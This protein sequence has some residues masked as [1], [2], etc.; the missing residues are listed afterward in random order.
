MKKRNLSL[1]ISTDHF[2]E[3]PNQAKV[4]RFFN[5]KISDIVIYD[6]VG[7]PTLPNIIRK[8]DKVKCLIM[9]KSCWIKDSKI[10]IDLKLVQIMRTSPFS[11]I[12]KKT[13][14]VEKTPIRYNKNNQIHTPPPPPLPKIQLTLNVNSNP[15]SLISIKDIQE[16]RSKLK[17][18]KKK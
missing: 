7:N 15:L 8:E 17:N 14:M 6:E 9:L 12:N 5:V 10:G 4:L 3:Y 2:K 11:E 13:H 1:N 16:A 18:N